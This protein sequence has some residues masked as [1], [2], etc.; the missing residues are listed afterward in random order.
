M[1]VVKLGGSLD[2]AG[3]LGEW[4]RALAFAPTRSASPLLVVPG[5]GPFADAVRAAQQRWP[6]DDRTAHAMAV[7]AMEQMAHL[8]CALAPSMARTDDVDDP[9]P[10]F[11]VPTARVWHPCRELLGG[12][13]RDAGEI[14]ADWTVTS[15]SLAAIVAARIRAQ[16][17]V[18]I[19]SAPLQA[20]AATV[21][22]LQSSG[23]VDAAF[24]DFG[25]RCGCPVWLVGGSR[26]GVLCDLLGG[27]ARAAVRVRF[28]SA[29]MPAP[30]R[31]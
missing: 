31:G 3:R 24:H 13:W 29:A 12:G 23:V 6:F 1:W 5:G 30:G 8:L 4:A 10:S 15:D 25:A 21:E 11:G 16:G 20:V 14:P 19:K 28:D 18:L 17:L 7:L 22:R 26:P 9:P 2:A 27:D